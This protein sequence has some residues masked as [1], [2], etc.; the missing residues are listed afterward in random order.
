ML[1]LGPLLQHLKSQSSLHHIMGE[2]DQFI[3]KRKRKRVRKRKKFNSEADMSTDTTPPEIS[4][5]SQIPMNS[6]GCPSLHIK[7]E[8]DNEN[9]DNIKIVKI[10]EAEEDKEQNVE[11]INITSDQEVFINED[12]I[13]KAPSMENI[14]PKVGDIIAFKVS[15]INR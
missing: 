9:E 15:V 14:L 5:H 1:F 2:T 6:K 3:T 4:N 7:Y 10:N 8:Y 13:S 11:I 12:N